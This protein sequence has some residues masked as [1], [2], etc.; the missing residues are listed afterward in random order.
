MEHGR[1]FV[2]TGGKVVTPEA[3]FE[4]AV[5]VR[6]GRIVRVG[7][8]D[9]REA[10]SAEI[11]PLHSAWV[12]PGLIDMHI[13]DGVAILRNLSTPEEHAA[14]L[15]EVSRGLIN[16]GITGIFLATLAGPPESLRD[17]LEGLA[18]FRGRWKT[19]P[20]GTEICGVLIE[21]TF[22]NPDNCGAHNP[23][24]IFPPDRKIL[25]FLLEPGVAR[26]VNI[27]PEYGDKALE[28]IS[29]VTE[30]GLVAA[31][32]HC[33]PTADQLSRAVD[34]GLKYFIHL[35]N[36]PT[37]S[38]TK[39]FYGGGTLEG[40]LRDD[41][42]AVE[43]I[44]DLVHVDQPVLRDV[45]SRK[46]ARRVVAVSD[47]MF[48][49][50]SPEAEFEINGILGLIDRENN[51]ISVVGRRA[52]NGEV[53]EVA[54]PALETCD[55]STL[56]G[57]AVNMDTV[58][59]NT[60]SLLAAEQQGNFVRSHPA[61]PLEEAVRQASLM[62]STNPARITGL[63]DG[64][65]GRKVGALKE[66]FEADIVVA[67]IAAGGWGVK[68]LPREVYLAGVPMLGRSGKAVGAAG[69]K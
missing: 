3:V 35:L 10:E 16:R 4:G 15:A 8:F 47:S 21:G 55:F 50:D 26:M 5:E 65:A 17:Y 25:D 57:S 33:K 28:L 62:C 52:E 19:E 31:A 34:R 12:L 43:L 7:R 51:V 32:G 38:N 23:E 20:S 30:R 22:M 13:N 40:A 58:F 46:E 61:L 36:G 45:I 2:L 27:A 48:P 68:F 59:P 41:R 64:S 67:E 63:L 69:G 49:S 54:P 42:L 39:A 18:I 37:G 66:G 44:V 56:Y 9:G 1:H 53:T 6:D 14:R 11:I 29:Y 24:Y 60:V